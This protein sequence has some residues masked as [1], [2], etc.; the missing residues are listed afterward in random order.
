MP[1]DKRELWITS[2]TF[3]TLE[4]WGSEGLR[5]STKQQDYLIC[6]YFALARFAVPK[7]D[8]WWRHNQWN[9]WDPSLRVGGSPTLPCCSLHERACVYFMRLFRPCSYFS[10]CVR[11]RILSAAL[12]LASHLPRT[13]ER[14]SVSACRCLKLKHAYEETTGCWQRILF[15]HHLW[16]L[17]RS[18]KFDAQW[19][20][21]I[22]N[23]FTCIT[24]RKRSIM[25]EL[26]RNAWCLCDTFQD[27]P[28]S[29][30]KAFRSATVSILF[31]SPHE[32]ACTC[33]SSHHLNP[34]FWRIC[35]HY[36]CWPLWD[37][38]CIV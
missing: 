26:P 18:R 14:A 21:W 24:N 33:G 10:I 25:Q 2:S 7:G 37:S 13:C 20:G 30:A 6:C 38:K 23:I 5:N 34:S 36:S 8:K 12:V 19:R 4:D 22:R 17:T 29:A 9:F 11:P 16:S 32:S 35:G 31:N 1:E 28:K 27:L 15:L 3:N